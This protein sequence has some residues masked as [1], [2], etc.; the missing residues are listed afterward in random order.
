MGLMDETPAVDQDIITE[1]PIRQ[2]KDPVSDFVRVGKIFLWSGRIH[3]TGQNGKGK[4][5]KE[6]RNAIQGFLFSKHIPT[7]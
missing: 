2:W 6:E 1:R 4:K 5:K 3:A 7:P